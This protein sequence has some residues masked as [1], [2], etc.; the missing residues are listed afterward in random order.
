MFCRFTFGALSNS[1]LHF[2]DLYK[3][4]S[5]LLQTTGPKSYV[6]LNNHVLMMWATA[7]KYS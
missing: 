6:L 2:L 4:H 1:L 7:P 3:Y 5:S